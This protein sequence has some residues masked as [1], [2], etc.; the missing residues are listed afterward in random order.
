M[1]I[2]LL[3]WM[4][5]AMS[6]I[7]DGYQRYIKIQLL[8][9]LFYDYF[10]L[11]AAKEREEEAEEEAKKAREAIKNATDAASKRAA[12]EAEKAAKEKAKREL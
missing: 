1:Y 6:V 12:E 11:Q 8:L 5:S 7:Y 3:L 4:Q 2:H 10:C 9:L